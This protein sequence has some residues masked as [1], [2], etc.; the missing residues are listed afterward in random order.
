M[1]KI[2]NVI[3]NHSSNEDD[4]KKLVAFLNDNQEAL[5]KYYDGIDQILDQLNAKSH[6]YGYM[7]LLS[8]KAVVGKLEPVI[9]IEQTINFISTCNLKFLRMDPKKFRLICK[10]FLEICIEIRQPMRAI[11]PL[12]S[13]VYKIAAEDQITPQHYMFT[14]AC[15][16]A[17][18][19]KTALS[20]LDSNPFSVDPSRTGIESVDIRLFFYYG[21]IVYTALKNFKQAQESFLNVISFPAYITS[22]IMLEAYKKFIL[23]SLLYNGNIPSITKFSGTGFTRNIKQR[24]QPYEDM[25]NSYNTHSID[26]FKTCIAIH[27]EEFV[28]D[29]NLGLVKQLLHSLT[30]ENIS[31]LTKTYLTLS[32]K[33][34][35]EKTKTK[36]EEVEQRI[37][38]M[39]RKNQIHAQINQ[40]DGMIS[41]HESPNEYNT[42]STIKYLDNNIYSTINLFKSV[43]TLDETITTSQQYI[44][45]M[46]QS[47]KSGRFGHPSDFE[48]MDDP[49]GTGFRG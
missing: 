3:Q 31:R 40:K 41:F 8:F 34:I 47:E 45:K 18:C 19:Y 46:V 16:K 27:N 32:L 48:L 5:H 21:G 29:N 12:R 37:L 23:V 9:F 38:K 33:N 20:L 26:D 43:R 30:N 11:K 1:N 4:V 44:Q 15:I 10:K 17:R 28:K 22:E 14:L 6:T 24:C 2:L 13:A 42:T 36:Q 7:F 35:G 39:I 25:I 49:T